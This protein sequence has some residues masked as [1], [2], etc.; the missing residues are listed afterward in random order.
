MNNK[1]AIKD[2]KLIKRIL[3]K[4][5]VPF[6]LNFG[7]LLGIY[8]DGKILPDDKDIDIGILGQEMSYE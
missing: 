8:R 7:T 6:F 1:L 3:D 5:K 2:L 4:L